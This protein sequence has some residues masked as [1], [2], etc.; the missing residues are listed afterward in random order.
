MFFSTVDL[1]SSRMSGE[2][3]KTVVKKLSL[4]ISSVFD[5]PFDIQYVK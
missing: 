3:F 4:D 5:I 1:K 2:S